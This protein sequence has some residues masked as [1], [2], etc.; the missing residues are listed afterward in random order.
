MKFAE[1]KYRKM[2]YNEYNEIQ[3]WLKTETIE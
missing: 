2:T 3:E 1:N